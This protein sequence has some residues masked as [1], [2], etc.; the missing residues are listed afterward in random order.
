M[1]TPRRIPLLVATLAGALTL[2]GC[3]TRWVKPGQDWL[4]FNQVTFQ[5]EAYECRRDAGAQFYLSLAAPIFRELWFRDCMRAHGYVMADEV[6]A[7]VGNPAPHHQ[8]Q[9]EEF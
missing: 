1:T 3:A 6:S 5:R 8:V 4:D 2:A 7:T 9:P